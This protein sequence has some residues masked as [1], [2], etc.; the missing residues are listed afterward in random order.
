M[1]L[2]SGVTSRRVSASF[3]GGAEGGGGSGDLALDVDVL[4]VERDVAQAFVDDHVNLLGG[5]QLDGFGQLLVGGIGAEAADQGKDGVLGHVDSCGRAA[6][7]PPAGGCGGVGAFIQTKRT[8]VRLI[9]PRSRMLDVSLIPFRSGSAAG[10]GHG[11][12]RC[13]P[14]PGAAAVCCAAADRGMRR[15]RTH[16][17][18]AGRAGRRGQGNGL[19]PV[20]QPG[21]P[22]DDPAERR[23]G[24]VPGPLHVRPAAAWSR[25]AAAGAAHRF[26]RRADRATSWNTATSRGPPKHSLHNRFEVPA[27]G[28]VAPAHRASAA[29]GGLRRGPVAYGHVP[30]L[31]PWIPNGCST[32]SGCT[33]FR[34]NGLR[35]LA[36]AGHARRDL[37][38]A[39]SRSSVAP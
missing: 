1:P 34:P 32:P 27:G 9:F 38:R 13:R 19:P 12:Q 17:G 22:H 10:S 24:R 26:R 29:R 16:H 15:G 3:G 31:P 4:V 39:G 11:T 35:S 14:E 25:G 33:A 28:A 6:E 37:R 7:G 23:R 21:R 36:P 8:A 30:E 2:C 20:R 5:V 18:Q